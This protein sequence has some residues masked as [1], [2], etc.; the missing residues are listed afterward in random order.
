MRCS[1]CAGSIGIETLSVVGGGNCWAA[2]HHFTGR[3][4]AGDG[5]A[6][7]T[8]DDGRTWRELS[9]VHQPEAPG[10]F[11]L[12]RQHVWVSW[13]DMSTADAIVAASS[14][15]GRTW[16]RSTVALA[17]YK[18]HFVDTV[19]GYGLASSMDG[20]VQF[21]VTGDGGR[22]WTFRRLPLMSADVVYF[23]SQGS[24]WILGAEGSRPTGSVTVLRTANAGGV[25]SKA[26]IDIGRPVVGKIFEWADDK[27]GYVVVGDE[28]NTTTSLFVT[29]DGG[30]SWA[31]QELS[32]LGGGQAVI[33]GLRFFDPHHGVAIVDDAA[34]RSVFL[35]EDGGSSWETAGS[36]TSREM[37]AACGGTDAS[38]WCPTGNTL[39]VLE[40]H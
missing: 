2:S 15:G 31:R 3:Q 29:K 25:W 36:V 21:G 35:T 30:T 24:G 17:L 8:M 12:D 9:F 34:R 16:R 7:Q 39:I 19:N 22:T 13:V 38:I 20:G 18:L 11:A 37:V 6:L 5:V 1:R 23:A 27:N 40:L 28:K 33:Q 10:V 32:A 26:R 4:G 14:D